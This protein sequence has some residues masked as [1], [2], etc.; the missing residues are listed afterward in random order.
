MSGIVGIYNLR[1][2]SLGQSNSGQPAI[3]P[4]VLKHMLKT[5]KH[6]GPDGENVWQSD[7][8][9][10]GHCMLRTTAE[11]LRESMPYEN[12]NLVIT[13]DARIDNREE[14]QILLNLSNQPIEEITDSQFILAAYRKWGEACPE[15]LLGD[16]AFAI[17]DGEQQQLF[18]ARDHFGVKPFYYF[19][20]PQLFT[21]ASEIKALFC[22]AAVPRQLNEVRI[23]DF[24]ALSLDDK[25]LTSYQDILRLPPATRM[26]VNQAGVRLQTYW[27]LDA[28]RELHLASDEAYAESFQQI[29]TEAVRC[30]LRSAYPIGSHLSGG[31][32]S[33]SIACVA[34]DFLRLDGQS[35]HTLSLIFDQVPECDERPYINTVLAQGGIVP[36]YI[37]GDQFSALSNLHEVFNYE[38]EALL[39][40]SHSYPWYLNQLA[41]QHNLRVCLDGFDGDTV[42]GHGGRRLTELAS[43][44]QW[45][46]FAYEA[47]NVSIHFAGFGASP[48]G[49]LVD[50]GFPILRRFARRGQWFKFGR[51]LHQ[52]HRYF[53]I[54][55]KTLFQECGLKALTPN[56]LQQWRHPRRSQSRSA[57]LANRTFAKRIGLEQ[58]MVG[59]SAD[60][61]M[62]VRQEQWQALTHGCIAYTLEQADQFAA[63]FG[64]E[65]R[66]PF[67]DKRL[68]EFCL[69]LPAEQ[70]LC[71]GWTRMILRRGLEGVLPAEI[72]WRGGKM[73]ATP[74]F[75]DG[76]V[77]RDRHLLDTVMTSK[78]AYLQD[79]ADLEVLYAAYQRITTQSHATE[80]DHITVWQGASLAAWLEHQRLRP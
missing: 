58:R 12:H 47:R 43:K 62:S 52:I 77:K 11:S 60:E 35:L 4:N 57:P 23:G 13:A 20:A 39:G 41:S 30:R 44:L 29:F 72:Q 69:A 46:T 10:L 31:L 78:I 36:H 37:N 61:P 64:V 59:F 22:V 15:K 76:L 27:Q 54:S 3:A 32:D 73:N 1:Q 66:H 33:S 51:S 63:R 42:V 9:G 34:R 5:L 55:R 56:W 75:I 38:D 53:N 21:F 67:M 16:F 48:K 65:M 19:V 28:K 7:S 70:K 18:C 50:Y 71:D 68:V 17:W 49:L 45:Q 14:L 80:A 6:R 25:V 74:N 8:I 24:L 26:V 2:P 40:P 79:R